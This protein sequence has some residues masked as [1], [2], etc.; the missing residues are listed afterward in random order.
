VGG[1]AV[2]V[3]FGGGNHGTQVID[4]AGLDARLDTLEARTDAVGG[5]SF[6]LASALG[7]DFMPGIVAGADSLSSVY[8]SGNLTFVPFI[9]SQNMAVEQIGADVA[10]TASGAT[11]KVVLAT[12]NG[13]KPGTVIHTTPALDAAS[14]TGIVMDTGISTTLTAGTLY[15]VGVQMSTTTTVRLKAAAST[16][17]KVIGY[18]GTNAVCTLQTSGFAYGSLP[19][20]NFTGTTFLAGSQNVP[21]IRLRA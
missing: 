14:S 20:A 4:N 5:S 19:V 2:V 17:G 1:I 13:G 6:L 9:P 18:N 15:W 8:S 7:Y 3:S 21:A 10:T 11:F 16:A 12:D